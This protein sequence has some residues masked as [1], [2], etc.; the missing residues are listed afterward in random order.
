MIKHYGKNLNAGECFAC[1]RK[2]IQKEFLSDTLVV[3]WGLERVYEFDSSMRKHIEFKGTII[4]AIGVNL[5]NPQGLP[6]AIL[7]FFP[8]KSVIYPDSVRKVFSAEILPEMKK[9]VHEKEQQRGRIGGCHELLVEL[10]NGQLNI[11]SISYV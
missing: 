1:S 5:R 3:F 9:W 7:Q 11:H 6:K 4:A 8:I 2:C 10:I